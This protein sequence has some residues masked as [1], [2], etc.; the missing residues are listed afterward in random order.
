MKLNQ[1]LKSLANFTKILKEGEER[2]IS[3]LKLLKSEMK[4]LKECDL[5]R[6]EKLYNVLS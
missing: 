5:N 6:R 3:D 1:E 2:H 4:L